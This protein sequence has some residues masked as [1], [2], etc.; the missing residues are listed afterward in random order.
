[1][2]NLPQAGPSCGA[3]DVQANSSIAVYL[4]QKLGKFIDPLWS[5]LSSNICKMGIRIIATHRVT[6]KVNETPYEKYFAL[7]CSK[8]STKIFVFTIIPLPLSLS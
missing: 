5:L 3:C 2:H 7:G 4:L 8:N 6:V 1:L